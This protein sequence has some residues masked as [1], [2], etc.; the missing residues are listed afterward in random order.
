MAEHE[1]LTLPSTRE[2]AGPAKDFAA[3]A[4]LELE[5]RRSSDRDFD[6]DLFKDAVA[7]VVGKISGLGGEDP[8]E[9]DDDHQ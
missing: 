2:R 9:A 5:R 8:G 7:L 6:L 4:E 3:F 1:S